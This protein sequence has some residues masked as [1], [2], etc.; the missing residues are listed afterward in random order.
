MMNRSA[1]G[2]EWSS[3]NSGDEGEWVPP[4]RDPGVCGRH[5]GEETS[6]TQGGLVSSKRKVGLRYCGTAGKPGGNSEH[7]HRPRATGR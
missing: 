2:E 6:V 3:R 1:Q 4:R 7:Q 5:G